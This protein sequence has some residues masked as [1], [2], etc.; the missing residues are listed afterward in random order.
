MSKYNSTFVQ[1][2]VELGAQVVLNVSSKVQT[3]ETAYLLKV[4]V[5]FM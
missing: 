4:T 1:Y 5:R 3:P 2:F